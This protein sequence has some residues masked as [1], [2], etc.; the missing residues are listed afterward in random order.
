[1]LVVLGG[2]Y[3]WD[4]FQTLRFWGAPL[5]PPQRLVWFFI[6]ILWIFGPAPLAGVWL[7]LEARS[8]G[9]GRWGWRWWCGALPI[10]LFLW[11]FSSSYRG[12]A[13]APVA[14]TGGFIP[15]FGDAL[16]VVAIVPLWML[17]HAR[18]AQKFV[19]CS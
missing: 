16:T 17:H 9:G 7:W 10:A 1:M 12:Y 14:D 19:V 2:A 13:T 4:L 15:W 18:R 3:L 6:V 5:F 8:L 11:L